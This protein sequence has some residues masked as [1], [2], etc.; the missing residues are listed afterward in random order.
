[1]NI[2]AAFF[3]IGLLIT[4]L[5][6]LI[7]HLCASPNRF[8]PNEAFFLTESATN[9]MNLLSVV[10]NETSRRDSNYIRITSTHGSNDR[11][12]RLAHPSQSRKADGGY[13]LSENEI[14]KS[15]LG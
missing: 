5:K 7:R 10:S 13:E 6:I 11:L 3:L 14:A 9:N 12:R 1:M 8:N 15:S 2:L 4:G